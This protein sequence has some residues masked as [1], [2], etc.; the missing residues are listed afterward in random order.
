VKNEGISHRVK[1]G[2]NILHKIKERKASW[3]GLTLLTKCFQNRLF[4]VNYKG[5]DENGPDLR[6]YW[7]TLKRRNWN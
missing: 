1:D 6:H 5:R 2:R 7:I 3:I 4:K